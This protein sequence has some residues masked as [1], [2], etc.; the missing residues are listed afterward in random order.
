MI[1]GR[2]HGHVIS[3]C[4]DDIFPFGNMIYFADGKICIQKPYIN[5]DPAGSFLAGSVFCIDN[6]PA[7]SF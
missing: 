3:A 2:L 4:A 7:N 5:C 6:V 1:Y